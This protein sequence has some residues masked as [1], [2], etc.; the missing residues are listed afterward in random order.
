MNSTLIKDA[1][2]ELQFANLHSKLQGLAVGNRHLNQGPPG[3]LL[4]F[5]ET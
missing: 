5:K 1:L 2:I 3:T 4:I